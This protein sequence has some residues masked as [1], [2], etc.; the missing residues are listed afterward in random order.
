MVRRPGVGVA[1]N[2]RRS[3]LLVAANA[4]ADNIPVVVAHGQLEDF[5]RSVSAELADGV[6]D[7]KQR[8]TEIARAAGAAA[9][10][11]FEDGS[12]ILLSPKADSH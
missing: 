2:L 12:K 5:L 9:I 4:D 6:E 7:P 11:P 10:Q 3:F 1:K 8:D